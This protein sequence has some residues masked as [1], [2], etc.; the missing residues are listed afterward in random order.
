[1][2]FETPL[3]LGR[4]I[5]RYKRFLADVELEADG[6]R[7][8]AACPNTGS[9]RTCA[10]PGW[11]VALS[12]SD[13]PGRKYPLTWELVHNGA[14]W[15]GINTHWP[16][17]LV[18]EALDAD[19]I[20][21]LTGYAQRQCERPYDRNSRIDLLLSDGPRTCYVEV[22][23]VTLRTDDGALA[24]PDAV[25][26]RGRKHLEALAAVAGTGQ[27]AVM[28]FVCPRADADRMRIAGE[29]D[30]DYARA[31]G[32][33]RAAGVEMLAYRVAVSPVGLELA[34]RLPLV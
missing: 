26:A 2:R 13:R 34:E 16:N 9:M 28:L 21:E 30:P 12:W 27:R 7:V 20:P 4:L 3:V 23:N 14:G 25:T 19:R 8:T 33:A 5:R 22:K 15:I 24:F 32:R 11:R 6:S 10:T 18:E 17:R 31:F 1:M 29:I